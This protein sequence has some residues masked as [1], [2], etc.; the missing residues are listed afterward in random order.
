MVRPSGT[1]GVANGFTVAVLHEQRIKYKY[2][3]VCAID[4]TKPYIT[5]RK[6]D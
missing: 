3:V 5:L 1:C 6:E 4:A 2:G